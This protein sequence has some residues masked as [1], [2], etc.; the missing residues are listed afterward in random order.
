M[1]TKT[2]TT[3][4]VNRFD[5][6]GRLGL[7][8]SKGTTLLWGCGLSFF[9]KAVI[10]WLANYGL[11]VYLTR[12]LAG[13]ESYSDRE[14]LAIIND[15]FQWL[16]KG[17]PHETTEKVTISKVEESLEGEDFNDAER[18]LWLKMKAKVK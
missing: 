11:F 18:A 13:K 12:S 6:E 2:N 4:K 17:M 9:S 1:N 3:E 5:Y 8:K 7:S 16:A 15:K 10:E 14:K